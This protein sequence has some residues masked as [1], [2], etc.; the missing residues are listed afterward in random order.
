MIVDPNSGHQ[1]ER[2]LPIV[3]RKFAMLLFKLDEE[4]GLQTPRRSVV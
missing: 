1:V 3:R 2:S 4:I